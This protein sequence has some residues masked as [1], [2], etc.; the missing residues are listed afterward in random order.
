MAALP[1]DTRRAYLPA[2]V[3]TFTIRGTSGYLS[4]DLGRELSGNGAAGAEHCS[5]SC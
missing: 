3:R 2:A 5:Q 1:S 4:V